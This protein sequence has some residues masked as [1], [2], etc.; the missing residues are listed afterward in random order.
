MLLARRQR[1]IHRRGE[2]RME[3]D[4]WAR[5]YTPGKD[6]RRAHFPRISIPLPREGRFSGIANRPQVIR[7]KRVN[8]KKVHGNRHF[9]VDTLDP[10]F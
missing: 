10:I 9:P 8:I 3:K 2:K 4:T 7:E 1:E 6:S 5:E